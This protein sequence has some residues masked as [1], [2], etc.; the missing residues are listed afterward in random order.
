MGG[1]RFVGKSVT[2]KVGR[3]L[4]WSKIALS[5]RPTMG[6]ILSSLNSKQTFKVSKHQNHVEFFHFNSFN[7][8]TLNKCVR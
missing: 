4:K 6:M 7:T 8:G 2:I 3:G 5:S 1:A